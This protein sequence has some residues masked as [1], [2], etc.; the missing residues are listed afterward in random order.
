[1]VHRVMP[2]GTKVMITFATSSVIFPLRF[3]RFIRNMLIFVGG[4]AKIDHD[5]I[6]TIFDEMHSHF[7]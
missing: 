3:V 7:R 1:M 6:Q 5:V 4:S 2:V